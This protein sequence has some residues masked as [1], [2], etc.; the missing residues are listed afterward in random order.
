[1]ESKMGQLNTKYERL[2]KELRELGEK[3]LQSCYSSN[4]IVYFALKDID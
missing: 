2:P 4:E 3:N 1:M